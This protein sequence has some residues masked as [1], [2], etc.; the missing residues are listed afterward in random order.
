MQCKCSEVGT[1]LIRIPLTYSKSAR[2]LAPNK[3]AGELSDVKVEI[4]KQMGTGED[5]MQ[6]LITHTKDIEF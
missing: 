5:N 3:Q 4:R 2:L 6:C 1:S